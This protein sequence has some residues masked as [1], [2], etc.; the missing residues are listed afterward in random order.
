MKWKLCCLFMRSCSSSLGGRFFLEAFQWH[1][2]KRGDALAFYAG[3]V[4][5]ERPPPVSSSGRDLGTGRLRTALYIDSID[6]L[7]GTARPRQVKVRAETAL[8]AFTTP[9]SSGGWITFGKHPSRRPATLEITGS[10]RSPLS[11]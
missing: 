7:R 2:A 6:Q 11:P 8:A 4:S 5:V 1:G 9:S 3:D 10:R